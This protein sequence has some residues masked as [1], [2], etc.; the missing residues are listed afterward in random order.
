MNDNQIEL[1]GIVFEE[2]E[3]HFDDEQD[4]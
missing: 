1:Q 2:D 3:K 4:G